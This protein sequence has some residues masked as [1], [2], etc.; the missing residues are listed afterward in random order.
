[1]LATLQTLITW[2]AEEGGHE[3]EPEGIDLVLPETAELLWGAIAFLVVLAVLTKVA[4]PRLRSAIEERE[5]KIQ[6]SLETAERTKA[7]AAGQQEEYKQQLAEAR[8]E[9]NRII[10]EARQQAEQVRRDLTQKAQAEAEQ[11]VARAQEQIDAERSRTVQELQ[12][13]IA[14]LSIELAEKVV[15]RS[16][17]DSSQREMVDAYIR[18]VG[19]MSGRGG[20]NN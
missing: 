12:G 16:L 19:G 4:F 11:I 5:R 8:S 3:A 2:A 17:D 1:M 20:S 7:E 14:D 13:T 10:E 6:E 9:A 15:G 18:E